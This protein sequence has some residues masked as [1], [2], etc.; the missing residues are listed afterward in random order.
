MRSGAIEPGNEVSI[1]FAKPGTYAYH[2]EFL[3]DHLRGVVVVAGQATPNVVTVT[4]TV[5]Q[6]TPPYRITL[7]PRRCGTSR[8]TRCSYVWR[9]ARTTTRASRSASSPP[10]A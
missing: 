7:P 2:S 8:R 10:Q 5:P 4:V 6:T 3:R 9:G 1:R